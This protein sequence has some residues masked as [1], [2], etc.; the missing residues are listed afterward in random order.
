MFDKIKN[1]KT[2]NK[3]DILKSSLEKDIKRKR[4]EK[5]AKVAGLAVGAFIAIP[6]LGNVALDLHSNIEKNTLN[7]DL[8]KA[9]AELVQFQDNQSSLELKDNIE[10]SRQKNNI[11]ALKER[12]NK[13]EN[14]KSNTP[15][16]IYYALT[17]LGSSLIVFSRITNI[18]K[19]EKL[20]IKNDLEDAYETYKE[21]MEPIL[22]QNQNDS[23]I[24]D[25][26]YKNIAEFEK[27]INELS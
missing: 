2:E 10:L 11:K 25:E 7:T 9:N 21:K 17:A 24:N 23:S 8:N 13:I 1:T 18:S 19:N 5:I 27:I 26:Y 20:N 22:I 6:N 3:D 4:M 14:K 15:M 12:I 16:S